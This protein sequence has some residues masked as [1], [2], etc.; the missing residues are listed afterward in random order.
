M[1]K[2]ILIT[3]F[4]VFLMLSITFTSIVNAQSKENKISNE[5]RI[6]NSS[7]DKCIL[8]INNDDED[9]PGGWL[10]NT[11]S[12]VTVLINDIQIIISSRGIVVDT[13]NTLL[14]VFNLIKSLKESN[15]L[16]EYIN[17][18]INQFIP[19]V[20]DIIV[21][22][23]TIIGLVQAVSDL[24][25][26]M[27]EFSL[28]LESQPWLAG[29]IIRGTISG[30]EGPIEALV[31][32]HG[33]SFNTDSSGYYYIEL[34]SFQAYLPSTYDIAASAEGYD[35]DQKSTG[36]LFPDG[37]TTVDFELGEEDEGSIATKLFIFK[38]FEF[39]KFHFIT[40]ILTVLNG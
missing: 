27:E 21:E 25:E 1:K 9:N 14:D 33:V 5:L 19:I 40:S 2:R 35:E 13:F 32:S 28:Y 8:S 3:A 38:L 17:V 18:I 7:I 26:K 4:F 10:T 11:Y 20:Q 12:Y 6:L 31:T 24:I 30:S 34:E 15:R 22:I 37:I 29:V 36:L 23:Q 16:I 39:R